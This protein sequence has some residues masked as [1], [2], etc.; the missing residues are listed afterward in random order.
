MVADILYFDFLHSVGWSH[1]SIQVATLLK[2]LYFGTRVVSFSLFRLNSVRNGY[3]F[4]TGGFLSDVATFTFPE[5][6][7]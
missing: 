4:L 7:R 1:T 6:E 5:E 2:K 3:N